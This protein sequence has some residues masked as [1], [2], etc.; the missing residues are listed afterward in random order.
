MWNVLK[1]LRFLEAEKG[2]L[3]RRLADEVQRN[4][5]LTDVVRDAWRDRD[6]ARLE[7][8][9]LKSADE[10]DGICAEIENA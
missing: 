4:E 2:R 8:A 7:L 1:R 5:E 3:E 10:I 9:R 6:A